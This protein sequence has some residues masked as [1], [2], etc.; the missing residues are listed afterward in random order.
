MT[1]RQIINTVKSLVYSVDQDAKVILFG[2]RA[3]GDNKNDSDWD[4]LILTS[5]PANQENKN[6]FR[7]KLFDAEVE[8]EQAFSTIIHN[9]IRWEDFELTPLYRNIRSEGIEL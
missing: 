2:S 3:R 7:D 9:K 5:L 4:F 8:L 6:K 1:K